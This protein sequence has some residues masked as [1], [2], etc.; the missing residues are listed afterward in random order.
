MLPAPHAIAAALWHN[1]GFLAGNL[2]TTA[3]EVALG[4]ALALL[5]GFALAVPSTSRRR[6]A[7]PS[8]RSRS[9]RRRSRSP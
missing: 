5:L 1:A 7:A 3:E 9:A 8:T 4:I 2:G 6:C